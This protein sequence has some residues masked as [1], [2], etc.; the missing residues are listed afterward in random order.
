VSDLSQG[1]GWWLA[2]DGKW[3]PPETHPS[4]GSN[5]L[6][7]EVAEASEV[8]ADQPGLPARAWRRYRGWPMWGQ[9]VTAL[10]VLVVVT[11]PFTSTDDAKDVSTTSDSEDAA[12]ETTTTERATTT[13]ERATTTTEAPMTTAPPPPTTVDPYAGE[14][15][16]QSNAR[17]SAASYLDMSGF[18]R[19]GLIEQLNYEDY[20]QEDSV[21]AADVLKP[22][23]NAEAAESAGS[24]LDMSGFSRKGLLDQLEYEG[25]TPEQATYG[26]DAQ[27]ADWNSEAAES[28]ASYLDMSSFSRAGLIDQLVYEGY[29]RAEAEYGAS[30]A[31]L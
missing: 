30:Q 23:W 2:S 20:S 4:A 13:T 15:V 11:A 24:Y 21:Y 7:T 25:Y 9:I 17:E 1:P 31:G 8:A 6:P 19:K 22:D 5:V 28:A 10:V 26:V 18:S 29:T 16:S 14:T 12:G 27:H 3:Y